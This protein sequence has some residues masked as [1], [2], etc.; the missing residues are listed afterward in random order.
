MVVRIDREVAEINTE[1]TINNAT[2]TFAL[3]FR[4]FVYASSLFLSNLT[5]Q[6]Y[7]WRIGLIDF[8]FFTLARI[9]L[10]G[11]VNVS[12]Y[13]AFRPCFTTKNLF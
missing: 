8:Y 5:Y 1:S 11:L 6:L 3:G 2:T 13:P 9:D 12:N 10:F 4:L 7:Y